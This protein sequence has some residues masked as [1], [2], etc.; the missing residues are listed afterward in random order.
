MKRTR[1]ELMHWLMGSILSSN[2]PKEVSAT[3]R[4]D[5]GILELTVDG[6]AV[7][8]HLLH[9]QP[10]EA[11]ARGGAQKRVADALHAKNYALDVIEMSEL[12]GLS[13]ETARMHADAL[14]KTGAVEK[15]ADGSYEWFGQPS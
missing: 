15:Y 14:T 7:E 12:T 2:N 10:V 8:L 6:Q 5:E 13:V 9:P 4:E 3:M 1:K 11:F